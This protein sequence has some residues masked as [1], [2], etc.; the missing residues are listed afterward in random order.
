[1]EVLGL[2]EHCNYSSPVDLD[3]KELESQ[4][5]TE[6]YKLTVLHIYGSERLKENVLHKNTMK[7]LPQ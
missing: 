7:F 5:Y 3:C 2:E 6:A 4:K 1:M